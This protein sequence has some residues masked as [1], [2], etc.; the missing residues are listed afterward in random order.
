MLTTR[1]YHRQLPIYHRI[2]VKEYVN[3]QWENNYRSNQR[4][5]INTDA[6]RN[7]RVF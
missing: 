3:D 2:N 4:E 1:R 5:I 7:P 6:L